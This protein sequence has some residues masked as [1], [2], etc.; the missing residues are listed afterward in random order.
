LDYPRQ[1]TAEGSRF[2]STP[3]THWLLFTST[4]RLQ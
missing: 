2:Y 4:Q 3:R 1:T